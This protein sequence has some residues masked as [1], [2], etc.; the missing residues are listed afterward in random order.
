MPRVYCALSARIA[1]PTQ[2][3]SLHES[4]LHILQT[5][6]L[7]TA[8]P[9]RQYSAVAV[10]RL[11]PHPSSMSHA[12][13]WSMPIFFYRGHISTL[14]QHIYI[15]SNT[16]NFRSL[17]TFAIFVKM[18]ALVNNV[19]TYSSYFIFFLCIF[20]AAKWTDNCHFMLFSEIEKIVDARS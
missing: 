2:R 18:S 17:Y 15:K 11:I 9:K 20:T 14:L 8:A 13:F 6:A 5:Y 1:S 12:V 4:L 7:K 16:E 10:Q 3:T 19:S